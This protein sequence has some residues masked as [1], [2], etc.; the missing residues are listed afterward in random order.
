MKTVAGRVAKAI[1]MD[2]IQG[3]TIVQNDMIKSLSKTLGTVRKG[4]EWTNKCILGNGAARAR[5]TAVA[6][7]TAPVDAYPSRSRVARGRILA[8]RKR[9]RRER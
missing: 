2:D 1:G 6:E 3:K 8:A 7:H 5:A 9:R 4:L